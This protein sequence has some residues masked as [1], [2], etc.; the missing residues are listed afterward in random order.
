MSPVEDN[1][2]P[3]VVAERD[4]RREAAQRGLDG[5]LASTSGGWLPQPTTELDRQ[6]AASFTAGHDAG[7]NLMLEHSL[8]ALVVGPK[9]HLVFTFDHTVSAQDLAR[10]RDAVRS[11]SPDLVDRVLVVAGPSGVAIVKGEDE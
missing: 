3:E 1:T 9:D 8:T 11:A 6:L 4:R 2:A 7:F 10:F 5:E